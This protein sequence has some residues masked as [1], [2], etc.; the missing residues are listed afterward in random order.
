MSS[1]TSDVLTAA[2]NKNIIMAKSIRN[3]SIFGGYKKSED[4]VTAALLHLMQLGGPSMMNY[5]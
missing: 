4:I 1:N 5:L 2:K 3:K